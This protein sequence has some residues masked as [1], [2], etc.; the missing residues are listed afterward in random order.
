MTF[1]YDVKKR[2]ANRISYRILGL[3]F[4]IIALLQCF[5]LFKNLSKHPMLTMVFAVMLGSYGLY[6]FIM[7]FRR[8]AYDI[9]YKFSEEGMLVKHRY[10]ESMYTFDDIEFITMIIPDESLIYYILNIKAKKDIYTIP[11][12]NKREFCEK[13]YDF[14]NERI[15]HDEDDV[16]YIKDKKDRTNDAVEDVA[17]DISEK[18]SDNDE[19][20][21]NT[22][23]KE[24]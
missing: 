11:F 5:T 4:T 6:L 2:K 19:D 13:V 9:T 12:T 23:I 3:I 7:S 10:G 20:T 15:K 17:K 16:I 8:Q 18:T 21:K 24:D 22:E 1:T 14:V